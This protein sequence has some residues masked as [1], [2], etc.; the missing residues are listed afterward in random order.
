MPRIISVVA[1]LLSMAAA[2][3][4]VLTFDLLQIEHREPKGR[5][6]DMT[7]DPVI[8]S[9]VASGK[10]GIPVLIELVESERLYENPPFD[11]WPEVREGDMALSILCDLFLDP[12][13]KKS[14][15]PERCWDNLLQRSDPGVPAW[16]LLSHYVETNGRSSLAEKWSATWS[17]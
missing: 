8:A 17:E 5:A 4:T 2:S 3:A 9:I 16:E 11:F 14:T 13:W 15:V 12:T 7:S 1:I 10:D 6:Q